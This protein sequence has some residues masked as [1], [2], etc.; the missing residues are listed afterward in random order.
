[1]KWR[2]FISKSLRWKHYNENWHPWELYFIYFY[3]TYMQACIYSN[4]HKVK[5]IHYSLCMAFFGEQCVGQVRGWIVRPSQLHGG[6]SLWRLSHLAGRW[7]SLLRTRRG[8]RRRWY[9]YVCMYL[10]MYYVWKKNISICTMFVRMCIYMSENIWINV[11]MVQLPIVLTW[12]DSYCFDLKGI[13]EVVR[14]EDLLLST[15]RQIL[16][17]NALHN[18]S[19]GSDWCISLKTNTV[20]MHICMY[21]CM[22]VCFELYG[23]T[24][25]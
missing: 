11:C 18:A 17:Q 7:I 22:F 21:V 20:W 14:G 2:E 1:M 4:K 10:C 15:A 9:G 13:T 5:N 12:N 3:T 16:L 6:D 24:V 8:C 25:T 19:T 23:E